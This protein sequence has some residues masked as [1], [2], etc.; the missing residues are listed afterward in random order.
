MFLHKIEERMYA[1]VY[2][3]ITL[4]IIVA[5]NLFLFLRCKDVPSQ[6]FCEHH[7]SFPCTFQPWNTFSNLFFHF[8][9]FLLFYVYDKNTH[10]S[11]WNEFLK[12]KNHHFIWISICMHYTGFSSFFFHGTDMTV[13]DRMDVAS[14][15]MLIF[16]YIS[17]VVYKMTK[18]LGRC[19]GCFQRVIRFHQ[20]HAW[21]YYW[22]YIPGTT[23]LSHFY[24]FFLDNNYITWDQLTEVYLIIVCIIVMGMCV[25]YLRDDRFTKYNVFNMLMTCIGIGMWL[26]FQVLEPCFYQ[27]GHGFLHVGIAMAIFFSLYVIYKRDCDYIV[28]MH[29]LSV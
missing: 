9:G 28:D 27:I 12:H 13:F 23:I 10:V 11:S 18:I 24:K 3:V 14:V 6:T 26:V 21:I 22:L 2:G 8:F 4:C 25:I 16:A 7:E 20:R 5:E 1:S 19:C 15:F 29:F 17:F